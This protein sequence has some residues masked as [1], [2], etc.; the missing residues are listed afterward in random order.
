MTTMHH[1]HARMIRNKYLKD[2]FVQWRGLTAAYDEGLVQGDAVLAA[3]VWRNVFK[4]D[5]NVDI[6]KLGQVVSYVRGVLHQLD[7]LEDTDIVSA[8]VVF[9]DPGSEAALV[10]VRSRMMDTPF[11]EE[12]LGE[13]E[14][15][16]PTGMKSKTAPSP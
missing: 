13:G 1:I 2:L 3:A 10:K 16:G 6:R 7:R 14:S 11:T 12:E 8:D 5:E 4:G 9:G 15:I